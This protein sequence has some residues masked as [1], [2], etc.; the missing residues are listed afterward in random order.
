MLQHSSAFAG[1][2]AV[3]SALA[4]SL[5]GACVEVRDA[6]E[7]GSLA[8]SGSSLDALLLRVDFV[9]CGAL[10]KIL[11]TTILCLSSNFQLLLY[12]LKVSSDV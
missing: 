12:N 10:R 7:G 11:A 4:V 3:T 6:W 9:K 8:E 2:V 5:S 1:A